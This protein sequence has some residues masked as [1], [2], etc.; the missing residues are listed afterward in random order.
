MSQRV[1]QSVAHEQFRPGERRTRGMHLCLSQSTLSFYSVYL[2]FAEMNVLLTWLVTLSVCLFFF[3]FFTCISILHSNRFITVTLTIASVTLTCHSL[4]HATPP[5]HTS[6]PER[7]VTHTHLRTPPT[8]HADASLTHENTCALTPYLLTCY[9]FTRQRGSV[10]TP[11]QPS[12][13][14]FCER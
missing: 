3:S 11:I 9:F 14:S 10:F 8:D 6:T 5:T 2:V 7:T 1:H 12:R 13:R 4:T